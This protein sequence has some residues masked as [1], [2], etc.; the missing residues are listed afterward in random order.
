MSI[1][2]SKEMIKYG[3]YQS[4]H[5]P[6]NNIQLHRR[7]VSI[8][9]EGKSN[10]HWGWKG[11]A[12]KY[13]VRYDRSRIPTG[14]D[15]ELFWSF[16]SSRFWPPIYISGLSSKKSSQFLQT[17]RHFQDFTKFKL[18]K[19]EIYCL[20]LFLRIQRVASVNPQERVR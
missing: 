6:I 16:Q 13:I 14:E 2:G 3:S 19:I 12:V 5:F 11:L 7:G 17:W 20:N 18:A 15:V 4:D 10:G 1:W 8:S 9:K